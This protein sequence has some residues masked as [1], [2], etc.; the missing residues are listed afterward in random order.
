SLVPPAQVECDPPSGLRTERSSGNETADGQRGGA[1]PSTRKAGRSRAKTSSAL[2]RA[3]RIVPINDTI[4]A[5]V[6]SP[7]RFPCEPWVSGVR[8]LRSMTLQVLYFAKVRDLV[9]KPEEAIAIPDTATTVA[10]VLEHLKHRYPA[11]G[12]ALPK[13]RVA[14]NETFASLTE[15]VADGD[16]IALIPPVAGG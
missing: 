16:T 8:P 5:A 13:V 6:S 12:E 15:P 2:G 9:G 4:G 7:Q 10:D 11:L 3:E 1:W 14:R